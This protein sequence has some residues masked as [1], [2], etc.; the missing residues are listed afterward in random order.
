M[1]L[2][3]ISEKSRETVTQADFENILTLDAQILHLQANRERI[4]ASI[5]SRLNRGAEAE[6]GRR[7]HDVEV[8]YSGKRRIEKLIVR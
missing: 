3:V 2:T 5:L 6:D 8:S 4:A 1:K 7:T